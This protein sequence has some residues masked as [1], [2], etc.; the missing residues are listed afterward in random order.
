[1]SRRF[2]LQTRLFA[3][4]IILGMVFSITGSADAQRLPSPSAWADQRVTTLQEAF[5]QANI[6]ITGRERTPR[7]Q[8]ELMYDGARRN[9]QELAQVYGNRP[10]I[11]QMNEWHRSHPG[12]TRDASVQAF[13]GFVNQAR[14]QGYPVS[15]HLPSADGNTVARDI[16]VPQ[17]G[18]EM[19]QQVQ[20][21]IHE[22]GGRVLREENASTGA[23]WHVDWDRNAGSQ[24]GESFHT[25][26]TAPRNAPA[27]QARQAGHEADTASLRW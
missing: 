23:H 3:S 12:A 1:M 8:A 21:R 4:S 24:T 6:A 10:Y 5:P 9:P 20:E 26:E 16:R 25:N 7:R 22:L 19:Q 11:Q 13:E 17:G 27:V 14:Q 18:P 15:N 2:H